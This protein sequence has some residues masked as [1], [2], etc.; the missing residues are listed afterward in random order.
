MK[1]YQAG[2]ELEALFL[3]NGLVCT[4]NEEELLRG[5]KTFKIKPAS[6]KFIRF[7]HI[8]TVVCNSTEQLEDFISLE[9]D[10]LRAILVFLKLD[11]S[12]LAE[13]GFTDTF[14]SSKVKARV[15]IMKKG[16]ERF[17]KK[18]I[19]V[20]RQAKLKVILDTWNSVKV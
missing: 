1:K 9:E 13:F 10:D 7:D 11:K 19:Q 15:K 20:E 3:S 12:H 6:R 5:K 16:L 17:N 14:D 2:E 4:S 18:G 8:N